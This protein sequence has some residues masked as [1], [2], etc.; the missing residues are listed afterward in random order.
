MDIQHRHDWHVS[1]DEAVAIQRQLVREVIYDRPL[2]LEA[3]RYVAGVDV[4][5]KE[6]VS[7]AA[8]VVVSFPDLKPVEIVRAHMPTP[9]PYIPGLLSFREGPVLEDAFRQLKHEPDVFIFDGMGRAHPRRI[10]IA[11]HMGLW[12]QK[13]TIGCGKTLLSG[14]YVEPP[15]ERGAFANLVDRGELIGVI[16]RTRAGVKPVYISVGHLADLATSVELVMRCTPKYRLPEPIR[17][18]H[19]AAGQFAAP[20]ATLPGLEE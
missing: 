11:T 12:L 10:G 5:V 17:L 9:F 18:A 19:N 1:P 4:S 15:D 14:K 20:P 13:P 16:L 6:N 2:N 7:Q 3:I 8:V